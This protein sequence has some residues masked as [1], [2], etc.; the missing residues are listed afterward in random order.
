LRTNIEAAREIARQI[1]LRDVGGII[2]VDFIDMDTRGNRER[3]LQELR[4]HLGRDR[5]RTRAFAVSEL[6][7]V[8]MTRQR[9]RASLWASMT[10]D[11]PTCEGTGRV[12]SP[13][14]VARRLGRALLRAGL[15]N[16]AR[17]R[18]VRLHPAVAI[19]RLA[20]ETTLVTGLDRQARGEPGRR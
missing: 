16:K 17:R 11:C 6:G 1:R 9:V 13:E 15:E 3:V 12:F 2:V 8:E 14:I 5:A 20:E 10:R 7:L 4:T 18:A 19:Y